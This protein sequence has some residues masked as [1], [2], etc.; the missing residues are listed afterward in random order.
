M[1]EAPREEWV[2]VALRADLRDG[3]MIPVEFGDYRIALYE[4]G[5]ELFATDST[6]THAQALL[7]DGTLHGEII[8]CP[9]HGGRFSVRTGKGLGPPIPCDLKTYSV[10]VIDGEIQ[11]RVADV[12]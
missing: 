9:L 2:S 1:S 10:R 3:A 6:C 5:G 12:F 11:V 8:E 4:V 7:T